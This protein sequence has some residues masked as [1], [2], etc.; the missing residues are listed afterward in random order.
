MLTPR[1]PKP[2][3]N[4]TLVCISLIFHACYMPDQVSSIQIGDC[5]EVAVTHRI[6]VKDNRQWK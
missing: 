5:V 2:L 4:Q 6:K 1:P 3:G